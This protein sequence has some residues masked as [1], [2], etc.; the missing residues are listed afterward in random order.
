MT[1]IFLLRV[2]DALFKK[3][4]T[5]RHTTKLHTR[6]SLRCKIEKLKEETPKVFCV[7][8]KEIKKMA[9]NTN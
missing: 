9:Q 1:R 2:L 4:F 5:T 8:L 3:Y 6:R 7:S